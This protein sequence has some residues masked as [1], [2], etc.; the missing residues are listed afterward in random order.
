[1]NLYVNI[2]YFSDYFLQVANA[3]LIAKQV[4]ATLLLTDLGGKNAGEKR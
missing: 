2:S 4:K 3:V 1:M